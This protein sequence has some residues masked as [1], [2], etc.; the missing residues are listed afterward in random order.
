M[1]CPCL[2]GLNPPPCDCPAPAHPRG[3]ARFWW[4]TRAC[5]CPWQVSS[6]GAALTA[7]LWSSRQ[8]CNRLEM[9]IWPHV[10]IGVGRGGAPRQC[11]AGAGALP[12]RFSAAIL[13]IVSVPLNGGAVHPGQFRWMAGNSALPAEVAL[14]VTRVQLVF[15]WRPACC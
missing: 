13:A 11:H 14:A 7:D 12:S 2:C 8:V 3:D 5:W 10:P 1:F 9:V 15:R 6:S 4:V